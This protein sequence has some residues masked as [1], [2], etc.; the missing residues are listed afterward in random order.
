M[1]D[2]WFV[3]NKY[4]IKTVDGYLTTAKWRRLVGKLFVFVPDKVNNT[5]G[6]SVVSPQTLQQRITE[7]KE[8]K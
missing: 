6:T 2:Q 4:W 3:D 8:S 1:T 5:I 7:F